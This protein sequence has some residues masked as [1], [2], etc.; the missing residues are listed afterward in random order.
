M[1]NKN[2]VQT[3][4]G[5]K[6]AEIYKSLIQKQQ[7]MQVSQDYIFFWIRLG[8]FLQK[9]GRL[10]DAIDA[11]Q[12]AIALSPRNI[13]LLNELGNAY[14]QAGHYGDAMQAY[15]Q[16]ISI[17]SGFGWSYSNLALALAG[18]GE[19][20][21]AELLLLKSV[22]LL[23]G[24]K[25]KALAWNRLGDLYRQMC[26]YDDA[27]QAYQNADQLNPR[28]LKDLDQ[29]Q[30]SSLD[31]IDSFINM[32]P[33]DMFRALHGLTDEDVT[34]EHLFHD[35]TLAELCNELGNIYF[36]Q[37]FYEQASK[38]Y[39]QAVMIDDGF[40]CSYANLAL[41]YAQKGD[42]EKSIQLYKQSIQLFVGSPYKETLSIRLGNLYLA[43]GDYY[44]AL[45]AYEQA[46]L[47]PSEQQ[48]K[49]WQ[50]HPISLF[51]QPQV[52]F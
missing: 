18:R 42:Y 33:T 1:Q 25:A 50:G 7:A 28:V 11:Y 30:Q 43:S 41:V 5:Q 14:C 6:L 34:S 35:P 24:N 31:L 44:N 12:Q 8:R 51:S 29:F 47:S 2:S 13:Y 27:S 22:D 20:R 39:R 40:G 17:D 36:Y 48:K 9:Q 15:F 37:G 4:E 21:E 16:A 3:S 46:N 32:L 45:M 10:K 52:L 23:S 49:L 26:Q 19:Y 38:A